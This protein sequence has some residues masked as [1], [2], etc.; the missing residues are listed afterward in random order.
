ML[1][2]ASLNM[3]LIETDF[4][5]FLGFRTENFL[6]SSELQGLSGKEYFLL[7]LMGKVGGCCTGYFFGLQI[8]VLFSLTYLPM[9]LEN[10]AR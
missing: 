8:L 6:S 10:A 4:P 2:P 9:I 7:P 3:I 1:F 5:L